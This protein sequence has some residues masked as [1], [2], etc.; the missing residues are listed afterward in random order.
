MQEFQVNDRIIEGRFHFA[1]KLSNLNNP[2]SSLV[3]LFC[4]Y[5]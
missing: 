4:Q 1:Y 2:I 3:K 5:L